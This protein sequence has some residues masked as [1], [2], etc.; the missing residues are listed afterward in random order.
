MLRDPYWAAGQASPSSQESGG[1]SMVGKRWL[2]GAIAIAFVGMLV[3]FGTLMRSTASASPAF[4][5][6]TATTTATEPITSTTTI[7][8]TATTTETPITTETSTTTATPTDITP[9]ATAV[10]TI[11]TTP[12][13]TPNP[14]SRPFWSFAAKFVCGEQP[15]DQ[16][17]QPIAGE[18]AVKPGNYATEINIHNPHYLG[19]IQIR[20]KALLLVDG[21]VP[22]ARVPATANP[23]AFSPLLAL[24]DDGATMM[25]CNGIWNLLNPGTTPP[26]PMPLMIGYLVVVSPANLD[27][28]G[29]TTATTANSNLEPAGI[30][31]ETIAV[32]GKRVLIPASAFPDRALPRDSE[33]TDE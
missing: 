11:T 12:I 27:V 17:G 6:E 13:T 8:E 4:Q 5:V 18:T 15:A 9:T 32:E 20:H 23:T 28:V 33:F 25:D 16:A 29:V 2:F 26:T 31:L 7:T 10:P 14:L 19:P 24:P 22:V 3:A 30:A 21:G 1:Y